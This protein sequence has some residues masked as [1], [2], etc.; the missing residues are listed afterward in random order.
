MDKV[1]E[2]EDIYLECAVDSRPQPYKLFFKHQVSW[3]YQTFVV[4]SI[5]YG[6][7]FATL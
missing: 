4:D 2:G 3:I 6:I 7:L 1:K 5:F